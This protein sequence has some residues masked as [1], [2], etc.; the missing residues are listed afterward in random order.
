[1]IVVKETEAPVEEKKYIIRTKS[2]SPLY[3][4]TKNSE[5]SPNLQEA[6]ILNLEE[7]EFMLLDLSEIEERVEVVEE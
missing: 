6:V 2:D 4:K 7:T 5:W 1:M 3:L